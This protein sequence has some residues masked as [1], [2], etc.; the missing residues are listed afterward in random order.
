MSRKYA[1]F[2]KPVLVK[3]AP[4]GDAVTA[5]QLYLRKLYYTIVIDC[6][7]IIVWFIITTSML[8]RDC[9]FFVHQNFQWKFFTPKVMLDP[10]WIPLTTVI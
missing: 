7:G 9:I 1:M 4:I 6:Q 3:Y 10:G 5:L 2:L 8:V